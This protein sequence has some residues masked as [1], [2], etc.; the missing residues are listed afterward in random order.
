MPTVEVLRLGFPSPDDESI[1]G[2]GR[3][4]ATGERVHFVV[5][6]DQLLRVLAEAHDGRRSVLTLHPFDVVPWGA[7]LG[8]EWDD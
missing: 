2:E 1:V 6:P 5:P 3:D 7:I 4:V 8:V